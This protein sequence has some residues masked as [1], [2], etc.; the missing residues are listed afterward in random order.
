M[1]LSQTFF[2]YMLMIFVFVKVF[3]LL[4]V[5]MLVVFVPVVFPVIVAVIFVFV[6]VFFLICGG[7]VRICLRIISNLWC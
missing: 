1:S 4:I 7:D 6:S 2:I 5:V 3:F